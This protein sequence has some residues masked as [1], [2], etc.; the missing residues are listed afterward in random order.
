MTVSINLKVKRLFTL[1]YF[2][3]IETFHRKVEKIKSIIL[4]KIGNKMNKIK[5]RVNSELRKG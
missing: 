2:N 1:K 4:I 5:S 3:Q